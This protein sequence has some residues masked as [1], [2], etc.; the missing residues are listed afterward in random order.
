MTDSEISIL[1]E[2]SDRLTE[3]AAVD[4]HRYL[5][6][7]ID[8]DEDLLCI[9]GPKGTGKTTL[10]LQHIRET[11]GSA[12]GRAVYFSLDNVWFA[13]HDPIEAIDYF[14]KN[15]YTHLFIDEVH[16]YQDWSRL[17]KTAID[18]YP[19][20][21]IAYSGSS[22][23]KIDK[24]Q[25]DLSRRETV[26]RLKGLSFR[27]FL[28]YE[29]LGAFPVVDFEE[30]KTAHRKLATRICRNLK[31]IPL[32]KRYLESGYYPFYR[33]SPRHFAD[34][35]A[36]VVNTVL[37]VDLPAVE[38]VTPPTV[39]KARKMLMVLAKSCP[40]QPNMS[41]LYRQLETERN[42]GLRLLEALERAELFA[43]VDAGS[44]KLK[45]LSRP[46][47]IFLGDTNLMKALVPQP[48][49]GAL[50]E[51]FFV[52]QLRAAGHALCVPA[53]GDFIVDDESLFEVGGGGKGFGQ[54][55]D[56][57]NS[58]VVNDDTE[59]GIGNRIPLWLFGFLY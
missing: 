11:F 49:V 54:I 24:G 25:A 52:N 12:S 6:G 4:F 46:E 22:I 40:Q 9:K 3:D 33:K 8:W 45:H 38:G 58:Y 34:R 15:G 42:M 31:I 53:R 35:L 23:L 27:E 20:I 47:K 5:Y 48:D 10:I 21:R 44:L 14:H 30:L 16:H 36:E 7:K 37:A 29:G 51:T 55:K 19:G 18:S 32:F 50:R 43:G 26:Y 56:I 41:E 13:D 1:L 2:T 59:V 28:E 39:R 57:S 17:I